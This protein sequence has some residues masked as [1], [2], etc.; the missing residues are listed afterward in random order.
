MNQMF[1]LV[2]VTCLA[3]RVKDAGGNSLK[4]PLT[5]LVQTMDMTSE[6]GIIVSGTR[7]LSSVLFETK[8]SHRWWPAIA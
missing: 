4:K 3:A 6:T 5:F 1:I 2:A 8:D 7:R